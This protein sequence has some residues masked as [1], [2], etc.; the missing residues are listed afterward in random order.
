M[1]AAKHG[2][3][4]I[5]A[6]AVIQQGSIT[7]LSMLMSDP[8]CGTLIA[9]GIEDNIDQCRKVLQ[10]N[11]KKV[12]VYDRSHDIVVLAQPNNDRNPDIVVVANAG[13]VYS[14]DEDHGAWWESRHEIKPRLLVPP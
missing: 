9:A 6:N 7:P 11:V 3:G 10:R 14:K 12:G 4:P 13:T 5:D 2:Q 1:I 8:F